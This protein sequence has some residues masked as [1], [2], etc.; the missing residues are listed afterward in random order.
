MRIHSQQVARSF[1]SALVLV[2]LLNCDSE[3]KPPKFSDHCRLPFSAAWNC[4]ACRRC[5]S[6]AKPDSLKLACKDVRSMKSPS[7]CAT[8]MQ[9]FSRQD[10]Y[11]FYSASATSN[12]QRTPR[13]LFA[14]G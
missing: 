10:H 1:N 2:A 12:T 8:E 11:L 6:R 3:E 9:A 4:L 14:Q 13:A 7:H 5:A